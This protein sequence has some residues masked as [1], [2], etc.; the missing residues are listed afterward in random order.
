M[1]VKLMMMNNFI[2]MYIWKIIINIKYTII[3]NFY[4]PGIFGGDPL[5]P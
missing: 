5:S 3:V 2:F 4:E 1:N